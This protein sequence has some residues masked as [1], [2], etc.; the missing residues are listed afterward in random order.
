ML[1][2]GKVI[3]FV[4]SLLQ[5]A[6]SLLLATWSGVMSWEFQK[7]YSYLFWIWK[8]YEEILYLYKRDM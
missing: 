6:Q 2:N 7:I 1:G 4:R 8:V 5:H 3:H